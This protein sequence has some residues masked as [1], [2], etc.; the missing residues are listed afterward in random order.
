MWVFV[1]LIYPG[2]K[3]LRWRSIMFV[4]PSPHLP[5]CWLKK[6]VNP[7]G[8]SHW[9]E[10]FFAGEVVQFRVSVA[11]SSTVMVSM[12]RRAAVEAEMGRVRQH[13]GVHEVWSPE[14]NPKHSIC[15]SAK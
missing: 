6:M 10:A 13:A 9:R 5:G 1:P 12:F 4:P 3:S 2:W 15:S 11:P 7:E 14:N 8:A